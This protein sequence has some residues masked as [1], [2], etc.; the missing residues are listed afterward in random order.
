MSEAALQLVDR[1]PARRRTVGLGLIL[2]AVIGA[3]SGS[4]HGDFQFDDETSIVSNALVRETGSVA[5]DQAAEPWF[6]S[7]WVTQLT[8][9]VTHRLWGLDV[10][11]YHA[12]NLLIHLGVVVLVYCFSVEVFEGAGRRDG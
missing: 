11:P 10:V 1:S 7:R 9:R 8:F 3:Y 12:T 5:L 4:L 6:S 2:L